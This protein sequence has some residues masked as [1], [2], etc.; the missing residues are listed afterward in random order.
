MVDRATVAHRIW[1]PSSTIH[2]SV[3]PDTARNIMGR[4]HL[5][6][7]PLVRCVSQSHPAEHPQEPPSSD[8]AHF[9]PRRLRRPLLLPPSPSQRAAAV[10]RAPLPESATHNGADGCAKAPP[11]YH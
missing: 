5:Q 6:A 9:G 8:W 10:L 2:I 3:S 7:A 4:C 1:E 11:S